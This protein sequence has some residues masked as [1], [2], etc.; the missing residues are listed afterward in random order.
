MALIASA[1]EGLLMA[2]FASSG[3]LGTASAQLANA[4]SQG[5][6]I[7]ILS[8]AQVI[9]IDTGVAGAGVGNSTVLGISAGILGP[10]M[11][12]NFASLGMLGTFSSPLAMAISNA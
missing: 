6:S 12:G 11:V 8:Q 3:V 9:T 7:N 10:I 4:L 5:I 1:F 2:E